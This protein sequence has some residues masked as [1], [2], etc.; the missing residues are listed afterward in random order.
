MITIY[1]ECTPLFYHTHSKKCCEY[2]VQIFDTQCFYYVK[3][4]SKNRCLL[5][6]NFYINSD[7]CYQINFS[8]LSV[9]DTD[10]II[11]VLKELYNIL[12]DVNLID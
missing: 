9:F 10:I 12:F 5:F 1:S 3:K 6:C 7:H 11:S 4:F 2:V 8:P